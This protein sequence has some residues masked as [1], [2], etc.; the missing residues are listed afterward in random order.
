LTT[1][2]L[3]DR[4]G[5]MP[6]TVAELDPIE[7]YY[8]TVPRASATVEQVGPF[9]LFVS[10]ASFPFYARPT[11]FAAQAVPIGPADVLAVRERQRELGVP[12]AFEWVDDMWPGLAEVLRAT[13]LVVCRLPL[14]VHR[15]G[16]TP[17][18]PPGV[19]IRM[20]TADDEDLPSVQTAIG[21]GFTT[22]GT[23]VGPV[24]DTERS[25]AEATA[26]GLHEHTRRRIARGDLAVA[27]AF[28]A[29]GAVGGGS[30]SPRSRVTEIT[31]VATLPAYRRRGVGAAVTARLTADAYRSGVRTCFLSAGSPAVVRIYAGAGFRRIGTACLAGAPS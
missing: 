25:A 2:T 17:L 6:T 31:G 10:T 14:M 12:E 5:A 13:G 29:A 4:I 16:D 19:S 11:M 30:H 23:A 22:P 28:A 7:S 21:L 26:V 8:D 15:G 1:T 18:P 3:R 20:L 27:G 24:G 9:T